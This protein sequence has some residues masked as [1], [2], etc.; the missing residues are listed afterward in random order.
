LTRLPLGTIVLVAASILVYFG[1]AQRLLD[2]MRLTDKSALA[3]IAVLI[4][5]S[6][7][8]IP[9]LRGNTQISL[10]VGGALVPIGLA[11]YLLSKAG[12]TKELVRSLVAT[13]AT[14][15][16]IYFLGSVVMKG[17]PGDTIVDPLY[18]Y[19]LV[20][21]TV[22]YIL[23][24][25]RRAAFIAAT[26]G[27]L[28]LD[29]I[30]LGWLFS[31]GTPGTV[32]IGGGGAFDSIVVAGLVAILLAEVIGE[33]RERLQGGPE[34]EGHDPSLLKNLRGVQ[35]ISQEKEEGEK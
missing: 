6:F 4:I 20:G 29:L 35:D 26:M 9:L 18:I 2:R 3:I 33:T 1:L 5:G 8:D 27:V 32:N 22:A 15:A 11:I 25:S 16:A 13:A 34:A 31:T 7:I 19:P 14:T 28:F 17:D 24:R 30:H 23:G 12:T 10:N 21:G